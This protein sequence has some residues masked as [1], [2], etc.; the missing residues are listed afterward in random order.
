ML[1]FRGNHST[2]D[3][4]TAL[5]S[6]TFSLSAYS[7]LTKPRVTLMVVLTT[8]AGFYLGS[9]RQFDWMLLMHTLF[10]TGLLSA[11]TAVLNQY[12]ERDADAKM[13]RTS[14][15]PLPA[16]V[17]SPFEALLFGMGL[18]SAG[19]LYLLLA[20]NVTAATLGW[21]TSVV[22]LLIYTPLKKRSPYQ[23]AAPSATSS[24]TVPS[25]IP[26]CRA[27]R[28]GFRWAARARWR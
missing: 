27:H 17:L 1:G 5:R 8:A 7:E 26:T 4:A 22:Y 21:L 24:T 3:T 9:G 6:S 25:T 2:M 18:V 13:K 16:G 11:G 12:L 28:G 14:G 19:T 10:G 15:R 23:S 20:T